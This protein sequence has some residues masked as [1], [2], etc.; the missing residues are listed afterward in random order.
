MVHPSTLRRWRL[1]KWGISV[2]AVIQVADF[3]IRWLQ[4]ALNWSALTQTYRE[5]TSTWGVAWGQL[6]AVDQGLK[7]DIHQGLSL[8]N[9]NLDKEEVRWALLMAEVQTRQVNLL[10]GKALHNIEIWWFQQC[11]LCLL[12]LR[13]VQIQQRRVWVRVLDF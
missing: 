6:F 3:F 7:K 12:Q 1:H 9:I 10:Q 11:L 2:L 5:R 13:H 8:I 4:S